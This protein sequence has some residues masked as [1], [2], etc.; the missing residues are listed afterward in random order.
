MAEFNFIKS[1]EEAVERY[2]YLEMAK[3]T[4]FTFI[5]QEPGPGII[6]KNGTIKISIKNISEIKKNIKAEFD[7][8]E[9]E[10]FNK[11]IGA[12]KRRCDILSTQNR[13]KSLKWLQQNAIFSAVYGYLKEN[14]KKCSEINNDGILEM[15]QIVLAISKL[16]NKQKRTGTI[17]EIVDKEEDKITGKLAKAISSETDDLKNAAKIYLAEIPKATS[18]DI[19]D[20]IEKNKEEI[21]TIYKNRQ[22]KQSI[23]KEIDEIIKKEKEN[24]PKII[25]RS[26]IK[27]QEKLN[28]EKKISYDQIK[29]IYNK[30]VD[31]KSLIKDP[32]DFQIIS[33]A[34]DDIVKKTQD[35]RLMETHYNNLKSILKKIS[36]AK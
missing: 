30:I 3:Q 23:K 27:K 26:E 35:A 12:V 14:K 5:K 6:Q 18:S 13:N 33:N 10:C 16:K 29:D 31:K 28:L 4:T 9:V 24:R 2:Y 17:F 19:K 15:S 8:V 34:K 7:K 36:K 25:G 21:L 32:K 11:L 20:F 1:I 22:D